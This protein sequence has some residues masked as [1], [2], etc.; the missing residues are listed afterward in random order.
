MLILKSMLSRLYAVDAL[1]ELACQPDCL[2][3]L[4]GTAH[5]PSV[6]A[7]LTRRA[8]ACRA[9]ELDLYRYTLLHI[10]QLLLRSGGKQHRV[11]HCEVRHRFHLRVGEELVVVGRLMLYASDGRCCIRKR[12][13]CHRCDYYEYHYNQ[14]DSERMPD[15]ESQQSSSAGRSGRLRRWLLRLRGDL[16]V[17]TSSRKRPIAQNEQAYEPDHRKNG[18]KWT[19]YA[20]LGCSFHADRSVVQILSEWTIPRYELQRK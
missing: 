17:L 16:S 13:I 14:G 2:G 12:K 1:V 18:C 9:I 7:C 8:R 20:D 10:F 4:L 11:A 5:T 3:Y 19:Q 6:S 15:A